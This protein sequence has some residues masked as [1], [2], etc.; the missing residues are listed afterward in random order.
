MLEKNITP[1]VTI[2]HWDLPQNLQD[3]GGWENP[4]ISNWFVEYARVVF[5][6][7]GDRVSVE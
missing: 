2:Y 5:S 3:L 7:F 4:E 6:E 1:F